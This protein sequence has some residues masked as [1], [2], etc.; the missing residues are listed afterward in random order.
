MGIEVYK[1]GVLAT[2]GVSYLVRTENASAGVM[3][4]ASHNPALDNGIKFFGGDGFNWMMRVKR[5]LKPFSM[6]QKYASTPSAEDLEP[7][8]IIQ[9]VFVN[10]KNSW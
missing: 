6:L 4:S 8:W 5:K 10:M 9:K 3:I 7:L 1:L 2:P